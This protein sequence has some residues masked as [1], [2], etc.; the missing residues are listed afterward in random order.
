MKLE[1][2]VV[3]ITGGASG[4]GEET[5]NLFAKEKAKVV[6]ADIDTTKGE[7]VS[8]KIKEEG[9]HCIFAETD[10]SRGNDV[11]GMIEFTM[12]HFGKLDILFNNA[13]I[14]MSWTD[15]EEVGEDIWDKVI[16]VNLKSMFLSAKYVVPIMKRQGGGVIINTASMGA[17]R[18][19]PH[20]IP[21]VVSKGGVITFTRALALE[22]APYHIRVNSISPAVVDTPL[23]R[24]ITAGMDLTEAK[25]AMVATIP[26][27][28]FVEAKDVAY[29]A[30]FLASDESSMITGINFQVDGGRGI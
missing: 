10:V 16:N 27:G 12:D 28:K 29:A 7:E 5:A 26:L 17:V 19:R 25:K 13:G 8:K 21:Y 11:K 4:I 6:I 9:G 20:T 15:L 3:L 30:L 14:S 18:I 1:N 23:F 2:K 24:K 22:L